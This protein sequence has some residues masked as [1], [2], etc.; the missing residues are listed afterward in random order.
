MNNKK[1]DSTTN[2]VYTNADIYILSI[3]WK[4]DKRQTMITISQIHIQLKCFNDISSSLL[5]PVLN[6]CQK[7]L[8]KILTDIYE[9]Q[10][11]VA[12]FTFSIQN[13]VYT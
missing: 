9:L 10:M 6:E 4:N 8:I 7:K 5:N 12:F 11:K 1:N 13:S 3:V 2:Y